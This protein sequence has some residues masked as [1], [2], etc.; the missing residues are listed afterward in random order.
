[1]R[2][3]TAVDRHNVPENNLLQAA[4]DSLD[5]NYFEAETKKQTVKESKTQ[6]LLFDVGK[7]RFLNNI[8]L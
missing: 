3:S 4:S 7:M 6:K 8:K 1:M 2:M 5:L